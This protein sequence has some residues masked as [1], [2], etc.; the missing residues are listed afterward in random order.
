MKLRIVPAVAI[1]LA[2]GTSANAANLVLNGG[3]ETDSMKVAHEFGASFTFGQTV[4]NWQ[5][6]STQALNVWEPSGAVA[7]G[8]VN[9]LDR[10]N[11][12]PGQYLWTLPGNADPDGGAFVM[13]DGDPKANGALTQMVGGLVVGDSYQLS[14]DWAAAQY[15][16]RV[17]PTTEQFLVNFGG[18]SFSTVVLPNASKSATN[19]FTVTHTFKAT[20]TSELLSFLSIGTPGGLPP[21]ALL[22]GV[23]LTKITVGTHGSVP[24]PASWA[25]MILGFSGLGAMLR[26]RRTLAAA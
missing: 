23:S 16:D 9:A 26:R 8:P 11:P 2:I 22:D 4:A 7:T 12:A 20:S 10:F 1:A 24:E 25:L 21:V 17:G 14:F 18:D 13:L 15:R 19:W 6:L 5:S 3:F